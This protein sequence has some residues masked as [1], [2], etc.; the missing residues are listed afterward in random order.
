MIIKRKSLKNDFDGVHTG[1][2]DVTLQTCCSESSAL[3]KTVVRCKY[4]TENVFC[5]VIFISSFN[6][7]VIKT[8]TFVFMPLL[9]AVRKWI[10]VKYL[11]T[12]CSSKLYLKFQCLPHTEHI[13]VL[14]KKVDVMYG[15]NRHFFLGS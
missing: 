6:E 13:H 10:H 7:I 9:N 3:L 14:Y 1:S 12:R 4:F 11:T 8:Q 15:N 5:S 2:V